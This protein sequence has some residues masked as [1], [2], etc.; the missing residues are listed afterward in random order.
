M[1]RRYTEITL[2]ER[3]GDPNRPSGEKTSTESIS[4][5]SWTTVEQDKRW[6]R[7]RET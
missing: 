4:E 2:R 3:C 7:V 5:D 6:F 1:R